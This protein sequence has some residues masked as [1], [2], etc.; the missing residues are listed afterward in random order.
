MATTTI[1]AIASGVGGGIGIIRI[2]GKDAESIARCVLVPWPSVLQ[3]HHLY[4]GQVVSPS[5]AQASSGKPE[6]IDQVL[7]CLMRGPRSYTGEDVVEIHG[8]GGAVTLRRIVEACLCAGARAAEPGEFTRRAFLAG[9]LDLTRAE[10][11]ASLL[12]AQSVQAARQAQRQL[13]GELGARIA[14]RRRQV[15]SLLADMEGLLDFPDLDEDVAILSRCREKLVELATQ[16][17]SLGRTFRDGGKA[18]SS[19]LELALLGRTNAGK[20][21]LVNAL[22]GSERVLV[23]ARPGTTRDFIEVRAEWDGVPVMLIDTAGE[24]ADKSELEQQGLRLGQRRYSGADLAL[25]VIDGKLGFGEEDRQLIA[26]LPESLPSLIVWNKTDQVDCQPVPEGAVAV[27]ALNGWGI[28]E[29]RRAVLTR[30]AGSLAAQDE[31]LV[32]S[33][34]QAEGVRLA[35]DALRRAEQVIAHGGAAEMAAAEL[36]IASVR[37]GEITGEEVSEAVLDGIFSRFCVGK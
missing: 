11:V 16:L 12:S 23:D 9:K 3:S 37:L 13:A 19:G 35:A 32:T 8:H 5:H 25:V 33:A 30:L 24:R 2:S 17:E 31:L 15:T 20:S 22:S 26:G 27:S 29:L 36:R 34:R 14:E 10:A 1:C 18:L 21:S 7:F 4:Y 28:S 6:V